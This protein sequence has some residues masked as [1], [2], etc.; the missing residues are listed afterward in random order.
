MTA[1]GGA[2]AGSDRVYVPNNDTSQV[3]TTGQT[4]SVDQSGNAG[5]AAPPANFGAPVRLEPRA[6]ASQDGPSV[7]V[8]IHPQGRIYGVYFGW[9]T[10]GTTT[11]TTDIVVVRERQLGY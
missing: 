6:T 7:R 11:N 4:A 8:A 5:T 10:L 3:P 9:R 1:L 2:G